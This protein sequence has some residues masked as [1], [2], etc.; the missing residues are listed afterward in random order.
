MR[1]SQCGVD[2][3]RTA[4]GRRE[5]TARAT[6]APPS[7]ANRPASDRYRRPTG[8]AL[9]CRRVPTGRASETRRGRPRGGA[10]RS[11]RLC[12]CSRA[13]R[14]GSSRDVG[15]LGCTAKGSAAG[16]AGPGC[17]L[18]SCHLHHAAR[19]T[20]T[21]RRK[22]WWTGSRL[23]IGT[24]SSC[25]PVPNRGA[26]VPGRTGTAATGGRGGWPG[27]RRVRVSLAAAHEQVGG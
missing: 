21:P 12:G 18:P 9:P 15:P 17:G 11:R 6:E 8:L 2:P 22:V 14:G 24:S 5:R 27:L 4:L 1:R 19:T 26:P 3:D 10:T 20:G 16:V 23:P 13:R 25:P 7:D